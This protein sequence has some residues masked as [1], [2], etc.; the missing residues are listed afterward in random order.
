MNSNKT[1]KLKLLVVGAFVASF[2]FL[3]G[4]NTTFEK[5]LINSDETSQYNV[6]GSFINSSGSIVV[7][8]Y[9]SKNNYDPFYLEI[10]PATGDTL[11]WVDATGT[12]F[13][14]R[15]QSMVELP[16]GGYVG[17]GY[18]TRSNQ[19]YPWIIKFDTD[20]DTVFTK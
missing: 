12:L 14:E 6:E 15:M 19:N 9:Q 7:Y 4:Q 1:N 10:D 3:L 2:Q 20:G 16:T 17:V 18:T 11:E 5:M 13:P 8:G